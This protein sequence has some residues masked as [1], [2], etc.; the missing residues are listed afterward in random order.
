MLADEEV[1]EKT[2]S[3]KV[4]PV[5]MTRYISNPKAASEYI[6]Q[7]YIKVIVR[8]KILIHKTLKNLQGANT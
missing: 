4:S 1:K 5:K 8:N 3:K 2:I 7:Y 6:I